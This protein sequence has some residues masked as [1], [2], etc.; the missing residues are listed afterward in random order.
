MSPEERKK[1]DEKA[2]SDK[3]RYEVEKAIYSG[4]WSLQQAGRRC[5]KD[6]TAPKRP[7]SAYLDYSK[8]LRSEVIRSN[9]QVR[10]NKEISKILGDMWR[11]ATDEEKKPFVEKELRLRAEYNESIKEWRKERDELVASERSHRETTVRDAIENGTSQQLIQAAEMSRRLAEAEQQAAAAQQ[12]HASNYT[13]S[14]SENTAT[15][16]IEYSSDNRVAK[17]HSA[18]AYGQTYP[19]NYQSSADLRYSYPASF[20]LPQFHAGAYSD[21]IRRNEQVG[22]LFGAAHHLQLPTYIGQDT[23]TSYLGQPPS[24]HGSN[25]NILGHSAPSSRQLQSEMELTYPQNSNYGGFSQQLPLH[26]PHTG[27]ALFSNRENNMFS[28][29]LDPSGYVEN[30]QHYNMFR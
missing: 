9:P 24:I 22:Q 30:S 15:R 28:G 26:N 6:K 11:S 21:P 17:N 29:P 10:D 7:M 12:N 1:W 3:A 25:W 19:A 23:R 27:E 13:A 2:E 5:K 18:T 8:T 16:D 14:S 20:G 4:P